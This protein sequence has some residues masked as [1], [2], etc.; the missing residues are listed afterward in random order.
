[1]TLLTSCEKDLNLHPLDVISEETFFV[2]ANDYKLYAN[3]FYFILPELG[4]IS[5]QGDLTIGNGYNEIANGTWVAPESDGT[6]N[7]LYDVNRRILIAF[8]K[9]EALEDE[10][11]I[12]EAKPYIAEMKFFLA[13][14]YLEGLVKFG[15]VPIVM[16]VLD[17]DSEGL[18]AP[19]NTREEVMAYII[20]LLEEAIADLPQQDE[21]EA[22][23]NGRV[24]KSAAQA[25]LARAA[26]FEGTWSKFHDKGDGKEYLQLAKNM[27]LAVINS[28]QYEL[29]DYRD[30]MDDDSYRFG[31]I[32]QG[33]AQTNPA[34][35]TLA[36]N[37]EYILIRRRDQLVSP[38]G[39]WTAAL[40]GEYHMSPTKK[41][42]DMF[43]CDDG[44]P[45]DR[46]GRFLGYDEPTFEYQNRDP[47]M[48]QV[49]IEPFTRYWSNNLG[50]LNRDWA[51]PTENGVIYEVEIGTRTRTGYLQKKFKQEING[52]AFSFPVIRL[53]EIYL[54]YAEATFELDE[55]ISDSDLDLSINKLRDRV[56]MPK[57]SNAFVTGNGLDMQTEIRR[58]RNIELFMETNRRDDLRRWKVAEDEMIKP[59]KGITWEGTYYETTE[60]WSN[61]SADLG[62]DGAIIIEDGR[63]F[64]PKHY[65]FPIPLRQ[66]ILN[67]ALE[68]NPGW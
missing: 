36:D 14:K 56:G 33:N 30:E 32:L 55:S 47:R 8:D 16:E 68:Q 45:I 6:W 60:P 39:S 37:K 64:K 54:I 26:L 12:E 27:A 46:S 29:W 42:A 24:T 50:P 19:R 28:K 2:T 4:T 13:M 23:D 48:K 63:E 44:L 10:S 21:L 11:V 5:D 7:S 17:L 3:N 59:V 53:A 38:G 58:E 57:L 66:I 61:I 20:T 62:E 43:L 41:Y 18:Y 35:L 15:G 52:D 49:L 34:N 31:F 25:L 1:M 40:F 22:A 9:Y 51:N 67:P 65:L